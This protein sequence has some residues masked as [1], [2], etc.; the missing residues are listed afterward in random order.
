MG[1]WGEMPLISA[2]RGGEEA[3]GFVRGQGRNVVVTLPE[4][5]GREGSGLDAE[6]LDRMAERDARRYGGG[7]SLY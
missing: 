5:E 3:A 1:R 2:V 4:A 7:F 6:G